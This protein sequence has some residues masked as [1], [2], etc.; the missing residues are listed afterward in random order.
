[1]DYNEQQTASIC[2]TIQESDGK[3]NGPFLIGLTKGKRS[4]EVGV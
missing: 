1:M 4:V 2:A 3:R